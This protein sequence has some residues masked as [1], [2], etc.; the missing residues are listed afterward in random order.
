MLVSPTDF[1]LSNWGYKEIDASYVTATYPNG[2]TCYYWTRS[3]GSQ[4]GAAGC[5]NGLGTFHVNY[6]VQN[7]LMV[8]PSLRLSI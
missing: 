4:L 7:R 1:A 8:C 6:S 5:V 3:A 2:G